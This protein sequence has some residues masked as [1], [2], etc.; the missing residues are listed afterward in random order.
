MSIRTLPGQLPSLDVGIT[1][2][3]PAGFYF[4]LTN[5]QMVAED[6]GLHGIVPSGVPDRT[7]G[8]FAATQLPASPTMS[9]PWDI[10]GFTVQVE[11]AIFGP[12]SGTHH[13]SWARLGDLWAGV[14]TDQAVL[15][16]GKQPVVPLLIWPP[17]KFPSDLTPFLK[18][19]S[20]ADD[21][22]IFVNDVTGGTPQSRTRLAQSFIFPFPIVVQP[23]SPLAF[24][25]VLTPSTL[26]SSVR[27]QI[28]S[29]NFTL[30]Y[31]DAPK[32]R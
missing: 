11:M 29:C 1:S 2:A 19:W 14:V 25:L 30:L 28:Y 5:V 23:G 9:H 32:G 31:E 4:P 15:G 8:I 12:I 26:D 7:P 17:A 10:L 27:I 21:D 18:L 13:Q 24:A 22:A 3:F 20:G 6:H 16:P